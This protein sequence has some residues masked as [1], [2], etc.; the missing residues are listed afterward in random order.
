MTDA[1][2]LKLLDLLVAI[3]IPL[4]TKE[5]E[6]RSEISSGKTVEEKQNKKE[7]FEHLSNA[8]KYIAQSISQLEKQGEYKK[9][10]LITLVN[11]LNDQV[12]KLKEVKSIGIGSKAQAA[13]SKYGIFKV[14]KPK[15]ATT[16]LLESYIQQLIDAFPSIKASI[17]PP[18]KQTS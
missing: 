16:K 1:E 4:Q 13:A 7:K 6:L 10:D 2:K 5:A 11:R 9:D 8:I 12:D 18:G 15:S 14:D 17:K 3:Q